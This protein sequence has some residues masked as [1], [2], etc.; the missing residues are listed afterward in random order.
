MADTPELT[1]ELREL[2]SNSY[3]DW[4]T[5]YW[6]F[7]PGRYWGGRNWVIDTEKPVVYFPRQ[8]RILR[9]CFTRPFPHKRVFNID[10]GKTAK[11]MNGAGLAQ[12]FG[13]WIEPGSEIAITANKQKQA[14][15]RMFGDLENS[16]KYAHRLGLFQ[17]STPQIVVGDSI[18]FRSGTSV[19]ALPI[20]SGAESGGHHSLILWDELWD[21]NSTAALKMYGELKRDPTRNDS[22]IYVGSY[23]PYAGDVTPLNDLWDTIFDDQGNPREG[24]RR[25]EGLEDLPCYITPGGAF[26][27]WNQGETYLPWHTEEFLADEKERMRAAEYRRIWV[28]VPTS[29]EDPFLDIREWDVL[30]DELLSPLTEFTPKEA[31]VLAVDGSK[32]QDY[33]AIVGRSYNFQTQTLDLRCVYVYRPDY[34]LGEL[35]RNEQGK[36]VVDLRLVREQVLRLAENHRVLAV[37][38]DPHQLHAISLD[39]RARGLE[40]HEFPQTQQRQE[41]DMAYKNLIQTKRLRNYDRRDRGANELRNAILNAV[42][43]EGDRGFRLYKP[44]TTRKIDAAVADA[45]A[46][47]GALEKKGAFR[48][49]RM[50]VAAGPVRRKRDWNAI[51]GRN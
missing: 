33:T 50:R 44:G 22:L 16:I 15:L 43:K 37:Y 25:P 23:S 51:Y 8:E 6:G 24:I 21:C 47:Y 29:P 20:T 18:T 32:N 7:R 40:C 19:R 31:I 13:N 48:A 1:P 39:W 26:V 27:H 10:I 2:F 38:Y 49:H 17:T 35:S 11:T 46:C 42:T 41:S 9:Y 5:S 14:Q 36:Y 3:V 4:A 12:W 30:E 45:M 28:N 34:H